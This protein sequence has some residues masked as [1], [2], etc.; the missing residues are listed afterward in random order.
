MR[1]VATR[2]FNDRKMLGDLLASVEA[3]IAKHPGRADHRHRAALCQVVLGDSPAARKHLD[4]AIALNPRYFD[5]LRSLA[6][7]ELADGAFETGE[8]AIRRASEAVG[9]DGRGQLAIGLYYGAAKKWGR[10]E[11]ALEQAAKLG[12]GSALAHFAL[13][14]ARDRRD[15]GSGKPVRAAAHERF[16]GTGMAAED[17]QILGNP[18]MAGLFR[19][20]AR[21]EAARDDEEAARRYLDLAFSLDLDLAR[22]AAGRADL[23]LRR[24]E[25]EAAVS[26]LRRAID[27]DSELIEARVTLSSTLA[28]MGDL[29]GALVELDG[30]VR[31]HPEYPDLHVQMAS[32]YLDADDYAHASAEVEA[33]LSRNGRFAAA[34]YLLAQARLGAGDLRGAAVEFTRAADLGYKHEEL[35]A[36]LGLARLKLGQPEAAE[37]CFREAIK[38]DASLPLPHLGLALL[39][40]SRGDL[41]GARAHLGEYDARELDLSANPEAMALRRRLGAPA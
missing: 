11:T 10:A 4:G 16:P 9:G 39:A 1:T 8:A 35:P 17:T 2:N 5:A 37:E 28:R 18:G 13:A 30:A 21:F 27:L 19:A 34:H 29:A 6:F 20:S 15:P 36:L 14:L 31:L 32:L 40:E 26:E 24:G 38:S 25:A 41:I 3:E 12:P 7:L 23:A 22:D 33:A